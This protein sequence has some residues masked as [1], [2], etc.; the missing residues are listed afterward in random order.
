MRASFITLRVVGFPPD[1][2]TGG[3]AWL[4]GNPVHGLAAD[5]HRQAGGAG[6]LGEQLHPFLR[7][8]QQVGQQVAPAEP[9]VLV[10]AEPV[11]GQQM[12][13]RDPGSEEANRAIAAISA[14]VSL[15]VGTTGTRMISACPAAAIR[16]AFSSIRSLPWE[17]N[18]RC[19]AL[20]MCLTSMRK[21]SSQGRISRSITAKSAKAVDSSAVVTPDSLA[22]RRSA[23]ANSGWSSDSP[24]ERV[25]PPPTGGN[26]A[27]PAG[28]PP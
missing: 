22:M 4:P 10:L 28:P 18:R 24:P 25:S 3:G 12:Q 20:S 19:L 17:V 16:R 27:S 5:L 23:P 9:L 7:R 21:R 8:G 14:G 15:K 11:V 2:T 6:G 26:R 13:P 1:S